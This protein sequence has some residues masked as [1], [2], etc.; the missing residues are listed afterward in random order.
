MSRKQLTALFL[1]NVVLYMAGSGLAGLLPVYASRLG[2]DA[3]LTGLFMAFGFVCLAGS[4]VLAGRLA[5]RLQKRKLLLI[6]GGALAV[7]STLLIAGTTTITQL[8]VL[9]GINYFAGGISL[10]MVNV[11]TGLFAEEGQRGRIFGIVGLGLPVGV[12]LGG[13]ASGPIVDNWGFPA[14]FTLTG[15]L[16]VLVPLIALFLYEK[17]PA[18]RRQETKIGAGGNMFANQTFLFLFCASV[19]VHIANSGLVF[20]K[21][22]IM[23]AFEFD[24]TAISSTGAVGGLI[25]LPLPLLVGWLSD[26]LG[27]KPFIVVCY[28]ATAAGLLV[29]ALAFD[30]WHFWVASALQTILTGSLVVGSAL[31]TDMFPRDSLDAP[32]SVF[33]S[34]PWFGFIIGFGGSGAAINAFETTPT[35]IFG[36]LLT[37]IGILL[38]IP[39]QTQRRSYT[40]QAASD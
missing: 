36:A 6:I 28:L 3:A 8:T 19:V 29:L 20:I 37:V 13:L 35:L 16:Y 7:P 31:I 34:T 22:L 14:L 12:L 15:L 25:S 38:L 2:A 26:R 5:N 17:P 1:C 39:V 40:M 11:I 4:G 33:S 23:D 18:P 9:V 24:A 32:L 10:T 27:R 30:L 21:P